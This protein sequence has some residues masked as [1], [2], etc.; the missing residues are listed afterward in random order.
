MQLR[1]SSRR[2]SPSS[3][4]MED[5]PVT[6]PPGRARLL[7]SPL[8]PGSPA[9]DIT[10]GMLLVTFMEALT[11]G[12]L[13]ATITSTWSRT[14]SVARARAARLQPS[15]YRHSIPMF[16]PSTYPSSRIP[17]RNA[18]GNGSRA[19]DSATRT[20]NAVDLPRRLRGGGERRGE[21]AEGASDESSSIHYWMISSARA[22]TDG[23]IVSPSAFAV[24]R[25]ITN[26]NVEACS[27]GRSAG[28]APFRILSMKT[29]ARRQI[30]GKFTA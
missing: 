4:S 26:S 18:S 14:S 13:S 23:G 2:L 20:P 16:L 10:I 9:G 1:K 21:D 12:V 30:T 22:S 15:A 27:T 3:A 11:A 25:L 28:L 29:A 5:R 17:V 19:A 7:T 8:A 24:G 6:F